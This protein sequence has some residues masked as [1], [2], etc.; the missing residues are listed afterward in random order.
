[1]SAELSTEAPP[2]GPRAAGLAAIAAFVLA[3]FAALALLVH[4]DV[5]PLHFDARVAS[6]LPR[7]GRDTRDVI[8]LLSLPG[9]PVAVV[10]ESLAIAAVV[11]TRTRNWRVLLFCACVPIL[12]GI[13]AE[14]LKPLVDRQHS[15]FAG[16]SS[17]PSGHATGITSVA[18]VAWLCVVA[19]W[20]SSTAKAAGTLSLAG[21]VV[22]VGI[23]RVWTGGHY[24]TDVIGAVLLAVAA[25]LAL[26]AAVLPSRR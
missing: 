7:V 3:A 5:G 25:T 9:N 18:V 23:S 26:A 11:S 10:L 13:S 22:I 21:V 17:F 24:A 4:G 12:V 15:R 19:Q 8:K 20:R 14:A 6:E 2:A 16:V 1:M